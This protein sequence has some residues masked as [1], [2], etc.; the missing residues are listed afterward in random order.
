MNWSDELQRTIGEARA[1]VRVG[2]PWWLRHFLAR[3]VVGITLGRRVYLSENMAARPAA[4]V[5]RL[6]RHEL[7]HVRQVARLG[8]IR[9]LWQY[10]VEY[11]RNR[12]SG[13]TA[14][15]AYRRISFEV[16]A[17]EAETRV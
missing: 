7:E 9:F 17:E 5:E 4:D 15:E 13:M 1:R 6:L 11:V 3:D 14:G 2:Y 12:R 16:E 10:V 8:L